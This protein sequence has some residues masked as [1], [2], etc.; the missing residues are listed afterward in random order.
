MI[1]FSLPDFNV[2]CD[3]YNSDSSGNISSLRLSGVRCQLFGI[4]GTPSPYLRVPKGTDIRFGARVGVNYY[5]GDYINVPSGSRWF[6][7]VWGGCQS[8]LGF[9]NEYWTFGLN[10]SSGVNQ[11]FPL[12]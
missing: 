5:Y 12:N 2:L 10:T 7:Q 11:V 8:H 6:F 1:T 4:K 9:P 3:V